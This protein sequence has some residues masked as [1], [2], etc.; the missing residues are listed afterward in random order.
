MAT[1][2]DL[3]LR[4]FRHS[5]KTEGA[6]EIKGEWN[7]LPFIVIAAVGA[8][9]GLVEKYIREGGLVLTPNNSSELPE[10]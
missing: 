5:R 6:A 7:G 4:L 10:N 3:L 2:G 9:A 1:E 8:S